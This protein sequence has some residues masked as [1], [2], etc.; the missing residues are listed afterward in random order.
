MRKIVI[1]IEIKARELVAKVWLAANLADRGYQIALGNSNSVYNSFDILKPDIYFSLS[2]VNH[3]RRHNRIS[4]L[5]RCGTQIA[6]LDTEGSAFPGFERYRQRVDPAILSMVDYYFA[7]GQKAKEAAI[8]RTDSGFSK[9]VTVSGNPRFDLLQPELRDVYHDEANSIASKYGDYILFNTNFGVNYAEGDALADYI[10]E[11]NRDLYQKQTRLIGEFISLIVAMSKSSLSQDIVVR[12]HP[13]E[14]LR[15]YE[16]LFLP[17]ENISV[18]R[19]GD[20]RPWIVAS[21]AVIHSSCTTAVAS[22]LLNKP[23]FAYTPHGL[24]PHESPIPNVVS[25]KYEDPDALI[26]RLHSVESGERYEIDADQKNKLKHHIA[27]I[28]FYSVDRIA[29]TLD[30]DE[31]ATASGFDSEFEPTTK[32]KLRRRALQT[33]GQGFLEKYYY[34]WRRDDENGYKFDSLT[35]TEIRTILDRFPDGMV[36][37]NIEVKSEKRVLDVFWLQTSG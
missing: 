19:D 2:A 5:D 26:E 34:K 21:D 1:P 29:N 28:D 25:E 22:A 4:T 7:W 37:D 35:L 14:D 17:F 12:P 20:V 8:R 32:T 13:S 33:V 3:K 15:L 36:P 6:V 16:Q 11:S 30:I 27:N 31:N 9:N 18:V 24:S 23:V 10:N